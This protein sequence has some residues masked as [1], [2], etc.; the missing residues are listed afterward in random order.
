MSGVIEYR[1]VPVNFDILD[2]CLFLHELKYEHLAPVLRNYKRVYF[3]SEGYVY[4]QFNIVDEPYRI[5]TLSIKNNR[6][7]NFIKSTFLLAGKIDKKVLFIH[8]SWTHGYFD[9]HTEALARLCYIQ[10]HF[11]LQEYKLLLPVS[12]L[13]YKYI[14]DSLKIFGY[15][16]NNIVFLRDSKVYKCKD[17]SYCNLNT[18]NGNYNSEIIKDVSVKIK[19]AISPNSTAEKLIYV[20]RRKALKRKV[21]NEKEVENT[22]VSFGFEVVYPEELSYSEQVVLFSCAK[23]LISIH[24]AG[25]TNMLFMKEGQNVLELREEND[26][27]NNCYF[28]LASTMHLNY[29]Y[30]KCKSAAKSNDHVGDLLVDTVSLKWLLLK[31]LDAV[32]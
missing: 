18:L 22:L 5:S 27:H 16:E 28:S 19:S 24:G 29:F 15:D 26:D 11:N 3:N 17:V 7:K 2:E 23:W 12:Y 6:F 20:S 1:N 21:V 8:D 13:P 32:I 31:Y 10:Q 25:L 4:Q 14:F 9:W 30:L